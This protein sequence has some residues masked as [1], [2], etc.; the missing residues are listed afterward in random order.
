MAASLEN[1]EEADHVALHVGIRVRDGVTHAGLCRE[2]HHL[3]KLFCGKEFVDRFLVGDV[4]A[5]KARTRKRRTCEH[6]PEGDFGKHASIRRT[7][8]V[9]LQAPVLEANIV[10]VVDVVKADN[11]VPA[12]RRRRG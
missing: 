11:L 8:T 9:F 6:L 3:V 12:G 7:E 5:H 1:V 4:H 2:V 10:I